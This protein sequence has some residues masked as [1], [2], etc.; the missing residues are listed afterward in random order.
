MQDLK[1]A[2]TVEQIKTLAVDFF[3]SLG[4]EY[5]IYTYCRGYKNTKKDT[6]FLS[7]MDEAWIE[8]YQ[9]KHYAEIDP[10][11]TYCC[12]SYDSMKMGVEYIGGYHFLSDD[13]RDFIKE[14]HKM[15]GFSA[16]ISV[17]M[18]RKNLGPDFGGWN[19]GTNLNKDDFDELYEQ[20][21]NTIRLAAVYIHEQITIVL[22][23]DI[24]E[25]SKYLAQT[26]TSQ[27]INCLQLLAEGY[28]TQQIADK[29]NIKPVTVEHHVRNAKERLNATTRE[30]AI[31][32]ALIKGIIQ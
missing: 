27:Q 30:Q 18:R 22:D 2:S 6:V 19:L 7:S 29:L 1:I 14:A 9:Q 26:L 4:I 8:L 12:D 15:T 13:E 32:R 20:H 17:I 11:F 23:K 16:G 24:N 31:A 5:V 21:K 10:F 28:R 3:Q 25:R